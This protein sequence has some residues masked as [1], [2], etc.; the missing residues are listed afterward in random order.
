[1]IFTHC[2]CSTHDGLRGLRH[3]LSTAGHK[4]QVMDL[5]GTLSSRHTTTSL[6]E[7][8]VTLARQSRHHAN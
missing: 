1:M 7:L 8:T 5:D 4:L 2:L 3:F 6:G